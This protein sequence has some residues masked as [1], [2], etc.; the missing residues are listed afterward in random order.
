MSAIERLG[1]VDAAE[2]EQTW[3]ELLSFEP[4]AVSHGVESVETDNA[5]A[6]IYHFPLLPDVVSKPPIEV[7]E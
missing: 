4:W 6:R 1:S 5:G 7:F 3:G 2:Q